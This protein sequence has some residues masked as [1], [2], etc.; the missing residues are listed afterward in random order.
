M[1]NTIRLESSILDL[2]LRHINFFNGR[3]LSGEDLSAERDATHA[4]GRFLGQAIGAGVVNGLEVSS[5]QSDSAADVQVEI[6]AGLA[7]NKNGQ[8]LRQLT[9]GCSL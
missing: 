9:Q 5:V 6:K 8:A 2:E 4:H 7:V 3:L 1:N